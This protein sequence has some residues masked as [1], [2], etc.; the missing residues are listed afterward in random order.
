MIK[1]VGRGL[2]GSLRARVRAEVKE[3]FRDNQVMKQRRHSLLHRL[4]RAWLVERSLLEMVALY[5]VVG[6]GVVAGE[7]A[8]TRFAPCL[9]PGWHEDALGSF[10][11]DVTSYFIAAQVGILAVVSVAVAVVTLLS[12]NDNSSAVKTDVRLYY[13]SSYAYELVTSSVAL[14]VVLD[15]KSVV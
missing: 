9:W 12:Q 2:T 7:V 8:I 15:R 14:L 4:V 13:V 1:R 3:L 10:I 11:K 6:V 5:F